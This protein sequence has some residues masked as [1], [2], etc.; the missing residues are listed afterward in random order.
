MAHE[1][2]NQILRGRC[3]SKRTIKSFTLH[4]RVKQKD[5]TTGSK[6][7]WSILS[8]TLALKTRDKIVTILGSS[9]SG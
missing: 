9:S 5:K 4:N 7:N 6:T 2:A 8:T 1:A 3:N